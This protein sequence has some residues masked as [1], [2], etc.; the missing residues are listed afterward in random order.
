VSQPT[1][2]RIR[3]QIRFLRFDPTRLF[4][5]LLHPAVVEA[6]LVEESIRLDQFL[7]DVWKADGA[8]ELE[9]TP[10]P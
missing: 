7:P 9:P 1:R 10:R 5:D 8:R 4:S 2:S 6:S 3:D